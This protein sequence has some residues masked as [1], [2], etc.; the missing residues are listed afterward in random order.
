MIRKAAIAD[1]PTIQKL[2]NHFADK[3]EML[4][5]SLNAIYENIRDFM[6]LE[7]DGAL[8]G[9]CALHVTW[10]D[11]AEIKSLAV[12][13]TAQGTGNGAALV[14]ACIDEARQLGV[15]KTFALTY[16][17]S[18]FEKLGF[19][20]VDKAALPHKIWSECIN[21]P[22]FPDCGEEAVEMDL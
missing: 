3:G 1:V 17:P 15:A 19:R 16:R 13:E 10:S 4:P 5:R 22:K 8:V 2:I 7:E 11:L 9:S 6:V 14:Q 12:L 20:P 21:C 18:F